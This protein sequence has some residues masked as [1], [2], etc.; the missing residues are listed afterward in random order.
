MTNGRKNDFKHSSWIRYFFI[1]LLIGQHW[2][3]D[4]S[5]LRKGH[6][7]NFV[8]ADWSRPGQKSDSDPML[9]RQNE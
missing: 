8:N 4:F 7:F 9:Y 2:L 5:E 3:T 1:L 6:S